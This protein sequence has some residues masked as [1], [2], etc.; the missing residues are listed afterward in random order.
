MDFRPLISKGDNFYDFLLAF[1][2]TEFH[3]KRI[4]PKTK[5]SATKVWGRQIIYSPFSE[6]KQ[7][8]FDKVVSHEDVLIHL[9]AKLKII[10]NFLATLIYTMTS[11]TIVST[12]HGFET[13]HLC[14]IAYMHYFFSNRMCGNHVI[15]N[16]DMK[17]TNKH[18]IIKVW[19]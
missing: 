5:E 14:K 13:N 15:K 4:Y 12:L 2:H 6:G 19:V 11:V 18:T 3:L 9:N 10:K 17:R 1:Q 7:N 16:E 8:H